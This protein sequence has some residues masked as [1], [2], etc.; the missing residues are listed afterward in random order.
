MAD[1]HFASYAVYHCY[2]ELLGKRLSTLKRANISLLC[3]H[4][5]LYPV[6]ALLC[7]ALDHARTAR[8]CMRAD[9]AHAT[10]AFTRGDCIAPL[11]LQTCMLHS[12]ITCRTTVAVMVATHPWMPTISSKT[13]IAWRSCSCWR[14]RG[15]RKTLSRQ[16]A[17]R[18]QSHGCT[19]T[20]TGVRCIRAAGPIGLLISSFEQIMCNEAS[21]LCSALPGDA[22]RACGLPTAL[23]CKIAIF[24]AHA[25]LH[26]VSPRHGIWQAEAQDTLDA[27]R[28]CLCCRQVRLS[29]LAAHASPSYPRPCSLLSPRLP[30]VTCRLAATEIFKRSASADAMT[31]SRRQQGPNANLA[32]S[33]VHARLNL[34]HPVLTNGKWLSGY[35]SHL[36]KDD[37]RHSAC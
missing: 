28:T 3:P 25:V 21:Q 18:H 35:G 36:E 37:V 15:C 32:N 27:S 5:R 30:Y 1:V 2:V 16:V 13:T 10:S 29:T 12:T 7:T 26:A 9:T 33:L 31:Q 4:T 6:R 22:P 23:H 34:R 8:L 17:T 24:C 20:P 11:G 14:V 19:C